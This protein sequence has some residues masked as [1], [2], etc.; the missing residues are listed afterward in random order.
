MWRATL[1]WQ[2]AMRSALSPYGLTHVQFVL[3]ASLW[4]LSSQGAA[5]SQ[6][7]L[8]E[9][10]G[11]DPMTTSQVVRRLVARR[12]V[13]RR[14]DEADARALQLALSREGEALL[15]KALRDVE[16]VDARYFAVLEDDQHAFCRLLGVLVGAKS[17]IVPEP[18][19]E[20]HP[21]ENGLVLGQPTS[22]G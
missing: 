6:R 3:L 16:Q 18:A 10:A 4:W 21:S 9:Q 22:S 17:A 7:R 19:S 2:R 5:P 8:A 20:I 12:L 11:T 1:A 13:T 14:T 15:A